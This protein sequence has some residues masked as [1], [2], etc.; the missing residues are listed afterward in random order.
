[1]SFRVATLAL[2]GVVCALA[3]AGALDCAPA[4]KPVDV[5]LRT[6]R[7]T[8]PRHL[9]LSGGQSPALRL[10]DP[11]DGSVLWSAGNAAPAS[12]IFP[13]M[14]A[15][16]GASLTVLDLDGNGTHDRIY[17]GDLAGRIWRFDIHH[18]KSAPELLTGGIFASLGGGPPAVRAFVAPADV[19]LAS[20][21]PAPWLN[22][23][24]GSASITPGIDANRFYVLRDH[25]P[26]DSWTREQYLDWSPITESRLSWSNSPADAQS[27]SPAGTADTAGFYVT[28]GRGSVLTASITVAGR[29][30]VAVANDLAGT[31]QQCTAAV[32]ISK[33]SLD[34]SLHGEHEIPSV[35]NDFPV[36]LPGRFPA[37][38]PFRIESTGGEALARCR[39]GDS[40]ID[41]CEASLQLHPVWWRREDAD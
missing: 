23:S 34:T 3:D 28:I 16:F 1:M 2:S 22:V 35:P 26:F 15:G 18:G 17:A 30:I 9:M 41:G 37:S 25:F 21:A 31:G 36:A 13:S 19:S 12:Q 40:I 4:A 39:F 10:V 8:G 6:D 32:T 33:L 20:S 14:W 29:A 11:A 27:A 24:I 5:V 7:D 38:E